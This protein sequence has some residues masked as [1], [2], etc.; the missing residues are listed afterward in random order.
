MLFLSFGAP[1]LLPAQ[2]DLVRVFEEQREDGGYDFYAESSHIIPVWLVLRFREII[3]MIP[4]REVPIRA[5][6]P[7]GADRHPLLSM[8]P[9]PGARR[10][11][12]SLEFTYSRGDPTSVDHDDDYLYLLPFA[13]GSKFHVGQGYEGR[14]THFGDNRY[15]LDFDMDIGTPIHAARG[16]LVVEVKEDSNVGGP[17]ASYNQHGNY[18]LIAHN[19][20]SFGNYVHLRQNGAVVEVGDSV[21]A[22]GLIGYSGNTGRSSG[23]HLHFDV[24]IPL[25]DGTMQS[26]PTRFLNFDGTA[27]TVEEGL[28]YYATHPGG[29]PFEVRL[30][31]L[32]DPADFADYRLE[33]PVDGSIELRT[34][35]IDRTTLVYLRNGLSDAVEATVSM[36]LRGMQSTSVLPRTLRVPSGVEVF[37]TILRTIPGST[38]S[39]AQ[40]SIR[41][42][43]LP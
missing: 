9:G 37:V 23:P 11:G 20:G 19:D 18:V 24:R 43:T 17:A 27:V 14:A 4:D 33:V 36:S 35:Q 39:S 40:S 28:F 13:H 30:G 31:R 12:Y 7:A 29:E 6:I 38:R 22:G 32:L 2:S 42:R 21:P 3:G 8:T 15:A 41:Y 5:A 16:G 26:V 10:V 25:E 1:A 34:E